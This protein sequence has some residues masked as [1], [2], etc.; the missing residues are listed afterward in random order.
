MEADADSRSLFRVMQQIS[1]SSTGRC[2]VIDL[3]G[4]HE[5]PF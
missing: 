5:Y 4:I 3:M 1:C 2:A